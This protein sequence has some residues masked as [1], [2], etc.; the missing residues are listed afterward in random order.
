MKF[1][2]WIK[3]FFGVDQ[4]IIYLSQQAIATQEIISKFLYY[5]EALVIEINGQLLI[6]DDFNQTEFAVFDNVFSDVVRGNMK[7]NRSFRMNEVLYFKY[8]N[9]DVQ[10][11]LSNLMTSYNNF[12]TW[13]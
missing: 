11:L 9:N 3:D 8:Y 12:Y 5:N 4:S 6:A 7:F 10:Q 2:D 13:R 1:L